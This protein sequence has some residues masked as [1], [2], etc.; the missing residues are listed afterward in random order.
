MLNETSQLLSDSVEKIFSDHVTKDCIIS[1][2]KGEWPKSLWNEVIENG[3]N[4]VLVP[5]NLGGVGGSWFDAGILFKVLNFAGKH[6]HCSGSTI[7]ENSLFNI[8]LR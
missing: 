2:E 8:K 3:L 7:L 1:A 4:L 5:E 6:S